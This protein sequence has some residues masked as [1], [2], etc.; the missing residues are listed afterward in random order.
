MHAAKLTLLDYK[1]E[2]RPLLRPP[3][4]SP[5]AG[6]EAQKIV[7]VST[8]MPF[9]SA[10]KRVQKLLQLAEKRDTQAV[11]AHLKNSKK[12]K[13]GGYGGPDELGQVAAALAEKRLKGGPDG[14]DDREEV[15]MKATGKA[16]EKALGLALWFQQRDEYR[17][18]VR[19]GSV[20]AIDDIVAKEGGEPEQVQEDT[21]SLVTEGADVQA[22]D[23]LTVIDPMPES[24][25]RFTSVVE[26]LVSL[27]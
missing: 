19:T 5:Y 9:M 4:A 21:Q 11:T 6:A 18:S 8:K 14:G 2:K 1:V 17:V 22:S 16:I 12:R 10:V 15:V 7:Y 3:I 23:D 25:I 26:I 27:R 13:S 20:G 24:R